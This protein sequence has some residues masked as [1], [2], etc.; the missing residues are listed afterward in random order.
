MEC[1]AAT[2]VAP[3]HVQLPVPEDIDPESFEGMLLTFPQELVITEYFNFDRFGEIVVAPERLYQPTAVF[4]PGSAEAT[5][6][7]DL[8][9]RS[10]MTIDDGRTNQNPDPAI[11]PNGDEFTLDNT[12][13][14]GDTLKDVTGVLYYSFGTYR[15]QPTQGAVHT[16][17]NPRT[18]APDVGGDL[19]VASFNVLNYFTTLDGSGSICGP[20]SDQGCR[21]ADNQEE[22]DRQRAKIVAALADIDADIVG[23]IE[24]ENHPTDA[25]IADLVAGLNDIV[26]AGTYDYV[27]TGPIGDDVIRVAFIYKPATVS[28]VG[29]Y[30][31]LDD[32]SFTDPLNTGEGRNRPA[33]AQTFADVES[34]NA[35]TVVVN[36]LKSKSGSEYD[37]SPDGICVDGDPGNDTL[38]C[39]LGDGQGYFNATRAAAAQALVDWL[40]TDPTGSGDADML[41]IGDLNAY[42]KEDPIDAML[43]G[44]DDTAD[45]GDDFVDLLADFVGEFAY[46]YVFNGQ[47]GYL[48][49]ALANESMLSQISGVAAWHINADEPDILDYDTSFKQDAQDALY[50]PNAYRAS[51]HDPIIV[52]IEFGPA[53]NGDGCYVLAIDGS[54]FDGSATV[55]EKH[56]RTFNGLVWV[57]EAGLPND[58]CL[59]IHGTDQSE[60]IIGS[61]G[62]DQIFGY[63]GR[64]ILIGYG[65]DD[66][67]TGGSSRDRFFGGSGNDTVTDHEQYERCYSVE[68]GC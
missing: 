33:L 48:D 21:G 17:A 62:D 13:R 19:T 58:S 8:Y 52:G 2:P 61:R 68:N 6:L 16:P 35:F 67:F 53:T 10:R 11:H 54:P 65:G 29:S 46:S 24:I 22:F 57:Y 34:G 37:D 41:V 59:E 50:E 49:Y 30:A 51:D 63:S 31:V 45:T 7:A 47:F 66:Q 4:E 18:A 40:D 3:T 25:A 44:A 39:D 42:D 9:A 27:A 23:L 36:H 14:G 1:G 60:I 38:D 43:V 20:N 12:F 26:G 15:L 32:V 56:H 55:V 64:D 28:T 5:D